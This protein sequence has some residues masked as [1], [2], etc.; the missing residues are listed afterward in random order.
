MAAGLGASSLGESVLGV[1]EMLADEEEGV[2]GKGPTTLDED[3]C[4]ESQCK[5]ILLGSGMGL[6]PS[7]RRTSV[8]LLW[9]RGLQYCNT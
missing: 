8:Y 5:S 6:T 1:L 3:C 2:V 9:G 7:C 4:H